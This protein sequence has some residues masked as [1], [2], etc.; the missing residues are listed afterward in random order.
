MATIPP[1]FVLIMDDDDK[2]ISLEGAAPYVAKAASTNS[3]FGHLQEDYASVAYNTYF[4]S[5]TSNN[6]EAERYEVVLSAE[7]EVAQA[8]IDDSSDGC[9]VEVVADCLKLGLRDVTS[10][11][12]DEGWSREE[13][14]PGLV[15]AS[16]RAQY[17]IDAF[18][19]MEGVTPIVGRMTLRG[20]S[21]ALLTSTSHLKS[22][23]D[24]W[25]AAKN[26]WHHALS[27][28]LGATRSPHAWRSAM[29][30]LAT[31][32]TRSSTL[33]LERQ[34]HT[35]C[36]T[37]RDTSIRV[38]SRVG[39]L[40]KYLRSTCASLAEVGAVAT[41]TLALLQVTSPDD[42]ILAQSALQTQVWTS[43]EV[44][45]FLRHYSDI[46]TTC[47][48][49]LSTMKSAQHSV[50]GLAENAILQK[51]IAELHTQ[52]SSVERE[53]ASARVFWESQH[54]VIQ[55]CTTRMKAE[56]EDVTHRAEQRFMSQYAN[57]VATHMRPALHS[58]RS[59]VRAVTQFGLPMQ[60]LG[61]IESRG[62]KPSEGDVAALHAMR[63]MI[64]KS[65]EACQQASRGLIHQLCATLASNKA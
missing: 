18:N 65:Q 27:S 39:K 26:E 22:A 62:E 45:A 38:V 37:M 50:E 10:A 3:H 4:Q 40:L 49:A 20:W 46:V 52:F 57:S 53:L 24:T 64:T 63:A 19:P 14:V 58:L 2:W 13:A 31:S 36:T 25:I 34:V 41:G 8:I 9:F 59:A 16:R 33:A 51:L 43:T 1:P 7:D 47:G 6:N 56:R 32:A 35:T 12:H 29:S 61:L 55:Q 54:L 5:D 48:V 44:D 60:T 28:V 42:R 11:A 30:E 17:Y 15:D 21:D 23:Y